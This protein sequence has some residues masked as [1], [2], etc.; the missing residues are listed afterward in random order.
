ML[1]TSLT[2]SIAAAANLKYCF[3]QGTKPDGVGDRTQGIDYR[4]CRRNTRLEGR[5]AD[6]R[7]GPVSQRDR[8]RIIVTLENEFEPGRFMR[9]F[10]SPTN[11]A[12]AAIFSSLMTIVPCAWLTYG[13]VN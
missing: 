2:T 5:P 11:P 8:A 7:A 6:L 1:A 3:K 10:L 4:L 13:A 12:T 9:Y